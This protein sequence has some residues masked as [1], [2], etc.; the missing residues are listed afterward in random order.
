MGFHGRCQNRIRFTKEILV[1]KDKNPAQTNRLNVFTQ[2]KHLMKKEIG[3]ICLE[4]ENTE[5]KKK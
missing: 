3:K 1:K 5:R 4:G 2:I